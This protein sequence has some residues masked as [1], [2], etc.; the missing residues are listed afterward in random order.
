[1]LPLWLLIVRAEE[2]P[3]DLSYV[4]RNG[5]RVNQCCRLRPAPILRK[6]REKRKEGTS[7]QENTRKKEQKG[8]LDNESCLYLARTLASQ[9]AS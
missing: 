1:M 6:G 2:V 7:D 4:F 3:K 9:P 8:L 5:Q